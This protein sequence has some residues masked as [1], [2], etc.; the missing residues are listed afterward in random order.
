MKGE[1]EFDSPYWDDI[2]DDA[3]DFIR[4]MMTVDPDKR[5]TC[6]QALA[7]AWISGERAST[8][9]ISANVSSQLKRTLAKGKWRRAYNATAVIRRMQKLAIASNRLKTQLSVSSSTP[10]PSA[11]ATTNATTSSQSSLGDNSSSTSSLATTAKTPSSATTAKTPSSAPT[12]SFSVAPA[13]ADAAATSESTSTSLKPN[14]AVAAS[15]PTSE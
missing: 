15:K 12:S 9:N 2:S 14:G 3:K 13:P 1:Y 4:H 5:Y 6:E 8:K 10:P 11:G 7:N